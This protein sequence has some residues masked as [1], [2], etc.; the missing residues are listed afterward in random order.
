MDI[1]EAAGRFA[2]A[3]EEHYEA[4]LLE[5]GF[6]VAE[7]LERGAS[8]RILVVDPS[9]FPLYLQALGERPGGGVQLAQRK[10]KLVEIVHGIVGDHH[11]R[12]ARDEGVILATGNIGPLGKQRGGR[13]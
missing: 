3:G 6:V 11:S 13:K 12:I 5:R 8:R 9:Y 2:V 4:A 7:D 10:D 1:S